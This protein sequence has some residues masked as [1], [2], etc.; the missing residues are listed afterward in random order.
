MA[1][2]SL[3]CTPHV[4]RLDHD[5]ALPV[6]DAQ[7]VGELEDIAECLDV[8]VTPPALL[9]TDVGG[10]VDRAEVHDIAAHVQVALGVAGM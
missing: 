1:M 6:Q 8:A 3:S 7:G 5:A 9:V 2:A 10:A 4:H